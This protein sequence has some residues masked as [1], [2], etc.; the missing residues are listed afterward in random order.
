[1][2]IIDIPDTKYFLFEKNSLTR[3]TDSLLSVS[4]KVSILEKDLDEKNKI[5]SE[6]TENKHKIKNYF[7]RLVDY[8]ILLLN[9]R[10]H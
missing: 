6:L 8:T 7:N 9:E 1:M 5:I 10:N 4:Q 2:H 3:L